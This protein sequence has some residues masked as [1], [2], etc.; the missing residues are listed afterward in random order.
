MSK[1]Q[2]SGSGEFAGQL[3]ES[4]WRWMREKVANNEFGVVTVQITLHRDR[5]KIARSF[6]EVEILDEKPEQKAH[7]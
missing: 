6:E 5:T 3:P 1:I 4:L 7:A 2:T